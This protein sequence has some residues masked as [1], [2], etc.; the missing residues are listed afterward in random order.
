[1][2][3][4]LTMVNAASGVSALLVAIDVAPGTVQLKFVIR[5]PGLPPRETDFGPERTDHA[6]ELLDL[7]DGLRATLTSQGFVEHKEAAVQ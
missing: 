2:S 5:A 4:L 6:T 3:T 1:M 7:V